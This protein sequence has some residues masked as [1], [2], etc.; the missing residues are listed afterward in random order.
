MNNKTKSFL[1]IGF[2]VLCLA[3]AMFNVM[4][5]EKEKAKK[6]ADLSRNIPASVLEKEVIQ[7]EF[8]TPDMNDSADAVTVKDTVSYWYVYYMANIKE[9]GN[10]YEGYKI[11]ELPNAYFSISDAIVRIVPSY[12]HEDYIGVKFFKRVPYETYKSYKEQ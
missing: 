4:D 11:I 10:E 1:T 7:P 3:V 5:T 12:K 2:F 8:V 6:K 9:S